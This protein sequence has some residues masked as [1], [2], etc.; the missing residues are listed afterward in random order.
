MSTK[1]PLDVSKIPKFTSKYTNMA[2]SL[3]KD[4]SAKKPLDVS[5]IPK[6]TSKYTKMALALVKGE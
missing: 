6:F 5:K 4:M 2:L 3:V 1:K